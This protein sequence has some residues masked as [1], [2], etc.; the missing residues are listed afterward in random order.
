MIQI[1]YHLVDAIFY[2]VGFTIPIYFVLKSRSKKIEHDIL[3]K[4]MMLFASFMLIQFIYHIAG[5][6]N[7]K[8][9]S[10][11]ILEPVSGVALTIFAII[12]YFSIKKMK[13]QEEEASI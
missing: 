9:L 4:L 10:K 6:L 8:L 3:V 11:G 12:Y 1:E 7:L 13:R 5:M 2:F